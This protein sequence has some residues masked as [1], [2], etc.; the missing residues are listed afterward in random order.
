MSVFAN[1]DTA[2]V[3]RMVQKWRKPTNP[4]S[5]GKLGSVVEPR[6]WQGTDVEH[7]AF[8]MNSG[9]PELNA[10]SIGTP[11][12]D[13]HGRA[14]DQRANHQRKIVRNSHFHLPDSTDC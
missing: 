14:R 12:A 5:Q 3:A 9:T 10:F 4:T 2:A 11:H 13:T 6:Q 1:K 7:Q 8:F